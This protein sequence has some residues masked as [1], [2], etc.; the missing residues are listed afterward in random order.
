MTRRCGVVHCATV[1]QRP[2]VL[3]VGFLQRIGLVSQ[4]AADA[5]APTRRVRMASPWSPGLSASIM[6]ADWLGASG[7]NL[8]ITREQAMRVPAVVAARSLICGPPSEGFFEAWQ[9][10]RLLVNQPKWLTRTDG[11]LPPQLRTMWTLDDLFFTGFSLWGVDRASTG[12]IGDAQRVP[13][14]RWDFD[15]EFNVLVDDAPARP[16][17]VILFLGRDEGFLTTGADTVRDAL[18]LARQVATR[19]RVPVPVTELSIDDPSI[20][21]T[22]G[23]D[24]EDLD[25]N[26]EPSNEQRELV[27]AYAAARNSA[28]GGVI[29][30]P[31][32]ITVKDHGSA[33]VSLFETGRNASVLDVARLTG[34][35]AA[36]LEASQVSASLTYETREGSR[37]LL[38]DRQ[39]GWAGLLNARLSMDDVTP[40]GTRVAL[41]LSHLVGPDEGTA[42]ASED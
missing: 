23:T 32:G 42:P 4:S 2:T 41:N 26:G 18:N 35:P 36:Q 22:D 3:D 13:P 37:T 31:Y 1:V 20:Q 34:I 24:P 7:L 25:E 29:L 40:R 21:L 8:P 27:E 33:D 10:D 19:V 15:G 17:E 30:T 16:D 28:N 12:A 5:L 14:E 11:D 9:K 6:A 38:T 39:R